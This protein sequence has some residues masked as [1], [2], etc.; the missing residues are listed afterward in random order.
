M[1]SNAIPR[2]LVRSNG[3]HCDEYTVAHSKQKVCTLKSNNVI[4]VYP[5]G[6]APMDSAHTVATDKAR[7][8]S[9]VAPEIKQKLEKLAEARLR[10]LSNLIEAALVE[11]VARAE[12]AG[13]LKPEK[14][15]K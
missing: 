9:Y 3:F 4:G 13:E 2:I 6:E 8:V 7:I 12:A 1:D 11:E 5:K 10:S 15:A 14:K